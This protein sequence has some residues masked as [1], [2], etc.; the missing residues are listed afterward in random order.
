M[1]KD[2][3]EIELKRFEIKPLPPVRQPK[4]RRGT[5]QLQKLVDKW[6]G[7]ERPNAQPGFGVPEVFAMLGDIIGRSVPATE[8]EAQD[9]V[10]FYRTHGPLLREPFTRACRRAEDR[11]GK[12]KALRSYLDDLERQ[13]EADRK[14]CKGE[15]AEEV[16]S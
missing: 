15:G 8:R 2:G 11:L 9:I 4:E 16:G 6:R 1:T 5:G 3:R 12:G 10:A 14:K 13:I 7:H